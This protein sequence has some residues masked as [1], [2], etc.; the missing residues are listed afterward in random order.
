MD[1][2]Q[3]LNHNNTIESKKEENG[4]NEENK[5]DEDVST[6]DSPVSIIL[7]IQDISKDNKIISYGIA[8]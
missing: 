4:K 3:Y 7:K 8:F 1:L 5:H 6:I 2:I